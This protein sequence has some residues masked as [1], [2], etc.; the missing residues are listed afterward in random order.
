MN[1]RATGDI[2]WNEQN[3]ERQDMYLLLGAAATFTCSRCEFQL[4]GRNLTATQYKTFYFL[5]MGNAFFQRGAP[6]QIGLT[7]RMNF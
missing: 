7:F 4:W 5:S 3:T 2:Y 6:R 1:L